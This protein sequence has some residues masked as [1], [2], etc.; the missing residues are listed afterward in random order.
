ME[1]NDIY[2][3]FLQCPRITTD[4]RNCSQNSIFVALRGDNFDGNAFAAAALANGSAYAIV[5]NPDYYD[6]TDKRMVLVDD[7]L[8]TLQRL[9]NHHRR[10]LGIKILAITGTNGKT[11]T[12]EL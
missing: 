6:A 7:C 10:V 9:A 8:D 2:Q 5:D 3:L 1:I 12:K 11:T 4:S